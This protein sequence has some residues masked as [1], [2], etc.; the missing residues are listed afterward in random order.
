MSRSTAVLVLSG[1]MVVSATAAAGQ[2]LRRIDAPIAVATAGATPEAAPVPAQRAAEKP[3]P[4][5]PRKKADPVQT[6]SIGPVPEPVPYA[7]GPHLVSWYQERGG[8][9]L[10][11]GNRL[12]YCH[13]FECRLR[14]T[15]PLN[16]QDLKEIEAIFANRRGSA[17]EERDA[18][19][20][21]VQWWEKRAAPLLG[22]PL[23]IRGSEI[24]QA[25]QPGQTDCLDEATNST[26]VL[27]Q[28]QQMGLLRYHRV[29]RPE[30]RGGFFYAHATAVFEEVGGRTWV[31]DSW[32]RDSGDP[33][34][35]MTLDE[36]SSKW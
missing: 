6:A 30:S 22:G 10:P 1:L 26:T 33:N 17:V 25:N 7:P 23:D 16:G 20:H 32:M 35:V 8:V 29:I 19:D 13:G 14:T 24:Y 28:A 12:V 21:L 9:P 3:K 34:D 31:V 5:K 2:E 11:R 15:V 36:W 27:L 4:V 18:I